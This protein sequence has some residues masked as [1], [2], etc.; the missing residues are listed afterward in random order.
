MMDK[1]WQKFPGRKMY[2]IKTSVNLEKR[3]H[4]GGSSTY[5]CILQFLTLIVPIGWIHCLFQ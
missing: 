5:S 4:Q 3:A 2:V 1:F